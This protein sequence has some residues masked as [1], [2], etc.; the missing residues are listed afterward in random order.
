MASVDVHPRVVTKHPEITASDVREAFAAVLASRQ[1][2]FDPLRVA[3]VGM[4]GRGRLL[5]F[6]AVWDDEAGVWLI[7]HAMLA[8]TKMLDEV[9]LRG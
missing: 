3:G 8:T 4:D 7:Y 1:R 2:G 9:G 5:Q 6:V